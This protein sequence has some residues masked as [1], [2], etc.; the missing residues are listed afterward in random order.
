MQWVK[1]KVET[2]WP[3]VHQTIDPLLPAPKDWPLAVK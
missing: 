1:G 2:V 3:K